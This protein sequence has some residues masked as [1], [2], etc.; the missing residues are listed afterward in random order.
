MRESVRICALLAALQILNAAFV[1]SRGALTVR[2]RSFAPAQGIGFRNRCTSNSRNRG[3]RDIRAAEGGINVGDLAILGVIKKLRGG[4]LTKTKVVHFPGW[5]FVSLSSCA[6]FRALY[7]HPFTTILKFRWPLDG[8]HAMMK[9]HIIVR[10]LHACIAAFVVYLHATY[11]SEFFFWTSHSLQLVPQAVGKAY[12]HTLSWLDW[13]L[14]TL[15]SCTST[16]RIFFQS[17]YMTNMTSVPW[18]YTR[19]VWNHQWTDSCTHAG[20]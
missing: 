7:S 17:L 5:N 13:L 18:M 19:K 3:A 14:T 6:V 2:S 9:C 4:D 16:K 15:D 12:T 20:V 10:C 1:P 8:D 11:A